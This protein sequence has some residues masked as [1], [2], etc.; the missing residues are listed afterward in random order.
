MIL[1]T[2]LLKRNPILLHYKH[3]T[4]RAAVHFLR[5]MSFSYELVSLLMALMMI[6]NEDS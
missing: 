4:R 5:A 2:L 1:K 6:D 3:L